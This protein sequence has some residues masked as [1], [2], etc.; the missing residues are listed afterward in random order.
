MPLVSDFLIERLENANA[1]AVFGVP[2][3]YVLNFFAKLCESKKLSVINTTCESQAGFA[4]DAHAR[5]HGIGVVCVTYN[6]GALK[7]CNAVAGA[8]AEKSPVLVI[9]GSPGLK[10]R[11]EEV[12]LHHQVRGYDNQYEIFKKLT[13]HAVILDNPLTAGYEIDRAFEALQHH[14][15]PVYIELP[16]DVADKPV[17]YD[18]YRQ[19]TPKA[20]ATSQENLQEALEEVC[21]WITQAKR[22][23]VLAGVEIARFGLA[24][25]MMRFIERSKVP[26]ATTMLSKSVVSELH[27]MHVGI[28][29]GMSSHQHV[30]QTVEESDCLLILGETLSDMT[31]GFRPS[32]FSH[33]NTLYCTTDSLRVRNHTYTHVGFSDFCNALFRLQVASSGEYVPVKIDRKAFVPKAGAKLTTVRLFEKI[34]SVLNENTAV[35]ADVGDALYGAVDLCVSPQPHSFLGMAFYGSMGFSIPGALGLN[36]AR[37]DLRTIVLVGDGAFQMCCTELSTIASRGYA[38]IVIVLNNGGYTT[39]RYLKDG[40]FNDIRNWKYEAFPSL[41]GAGTGYRAETEDE[42]ET[43]LVS[44][45]KSKELSIVNVILGSKD[46]SPALRRM[47]EELTKRV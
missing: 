12:A 7:V 19:L 32:K 22:P 31:L 34:N 38:P 44:A 21:H 35:V 43:A 30:K 47:T 28:Y 4:A 14:K 29:T 2:G 37:P 42:L 16:R 5:V 46:I 24:R 1:Q 41:I 39:E 20:P 45:F 40:K 26:V 36:A 13:C 11:S 10:E 15:Q 17:G 25:E 3:D 33:K 6:V 27:P 23:M 18:V 9:S 8:L